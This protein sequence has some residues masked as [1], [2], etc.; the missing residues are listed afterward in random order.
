MTQDFIQRLMRAK[1]EY[2]GV[3]GGLVGGVLAI[4]IEFSN[5]AR[6]EREREWEHHRRLKDRIK[7]LEDQ[8]NP[9]NPSDGTNGGVVPPLP[10][11][12]GPG[13]AH[14][15]LLTPTDIG[16]SAV[17][18]AFA[19]NTQLFAKNAVN[20]TGTGQ[21]STLQYWN[22]SVSDKQLVGA[23]KVILRAAGTPGTPAVNAPLQLWGANFPMSFDRT[24]AIRV[25][26]LD[27]NA[28]SLSLYVDQTPSGYNV[29]AVGGTITANT[30][31]TF[32]IVVQPS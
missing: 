6:D 27:A 4:I 16:S 1:A 20:T 5:L 19:I 8:V 10:V 12:Q 2:D 29:Y 31:Y 28:A 3:L 25:I 15:Y 11:P 14:D 24:P 13:T 26:P 21:G 32:Q 17:S 18:G 30:N 22:I 9:T 23:H 7:A